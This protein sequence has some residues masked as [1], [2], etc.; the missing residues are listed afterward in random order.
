M[1]NSAADLIYLYDQLIIVILLVVISFAAIA[2]RG[3]SAAQWAIESMLLA[4]TFTYDATVGPVC[5]S[6]VAELSSMRLRNKTVVLA[7]NF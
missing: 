7:R 3:N 5:Y 4:C 1:T 2:T 6:L